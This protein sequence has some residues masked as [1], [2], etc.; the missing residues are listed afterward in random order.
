MA[1]SGMKHKVSHFAS[2]IHCL[3]ALCA[4][5]SVPV[6]AVASEKQNQALVHRTPYYFLHIP[7]FLPPFNLYEPLLLEHFRQ[8]VPTEPFVRAS[9]NRPAFR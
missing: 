3:H 7:H 8:F 1:T 9:I 2:L 6:N 5:L 4:I